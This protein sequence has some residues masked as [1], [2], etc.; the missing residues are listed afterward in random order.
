[1][2]RLAFQALA[3]L[4]LGLGVCAAL[5]VGAKPV[6]AQNGVQDFRARMEKWVETR[7]LISE[8]RSEWEAER[9]SLRSTRE[10]LQ[11]E[12]EA[13]DGEI[14]KREESK[15]AADE[16]RR[17]L[18]L[19]R[20]DHQRSNRALEERLRGLEQ[21]V[22]ALAP[23]LPEPLREKL[24]VL[25]VQIPEDP[26]EGERL[27]QRLMNVLGVLAQAERFNDTATF[28]AETRAVSG[29]QKVQVRTLYWGLG[30]AIYV[31]AQARTAG[32]G[33]PGAEGWEFSDRPELAG[34][35]KRLLDIYE[36]NV[37]VIDFVKL[38]A[39]IR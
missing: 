13:L 39:E 3:G 14:R 10:L 28:V 27:G 15:A 25:L 2:A 6:G 20:G 37:D 23:Q 30:E 34:H 21:E 16:E 5:A 31:D 32:I 38:P 7:Q 33:R 26:E 8:E 18:L 19:A 12:K 24:D 11:R 9:E 36:G 1:M 4:Q 22:L 29:D 17:E 35:A